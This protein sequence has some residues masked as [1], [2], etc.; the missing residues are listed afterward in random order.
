MPVVSKVSLLEIS[1]IF[2]T[3]RP[4]IS[5]WSFWPSCDQNL[6]SHFEVRQ[7]GSNFHISALEREFRSGTW[8]QWLWK[9]LSWKISPILAAPQS[10]IT[11]Q[12]FVRVNGGFERCATKIR[13]WSFWPSCDQER[14]QKGA[15]NSVVRASKWWFWPLLRTE[16]TAQ[17]Y[18][19]LKRR[20]VVKGIQIAFQSF[21]CILKDVCADVA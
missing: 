17:C 16:T 19:W 4:K 14:S 1:P 5:I 9:Y 11:I 7:N 3:P 18:L 12:S 20:A 21:I 8:R 2:A 15:T 6:G 10:K 13:V